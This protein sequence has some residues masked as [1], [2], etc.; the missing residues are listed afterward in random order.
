M[1]DAQLPLHDD[2]KAAVAPRPTMS[3]GNWFRSITLST[4][5]IRR[6]STPSPT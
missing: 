6:L 5:Q 4:K 3:F 1:A 2:V